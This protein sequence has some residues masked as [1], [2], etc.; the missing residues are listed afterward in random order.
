MAANTSLSPT[1]QTDTGTGGRK[2]TVYRSDGTTAQATMLNGKTTLDSGESLREGDTVTAG[3]GKTYRYNEDLGYG[4]ELSAYNARL[5]AQKNANQQYQDES[6]SKQMWDQMQNWANQYQQQTQ[7]LYDQIAAKQEAE[8][9]YATQQAVNNLQRQWEDSKGTFEQE[10][11][12]TAYSS[13]QAADNLALSRARAGDRGGIGNKQY[14]EQQNYY[15]QAILDIDLQQANLKNQIDRQVADYIAQ[16]DYENA[17]ATYELGIAQMEQLIN[18]QNQMLNYQIGVAA[19]IDNLS[20]QANERAYQR[21]L[22]NLQLGMFSPQDAVTLGVDPEQAQ[23]VAD[24]YKIMAQLDIEAAKAALEG[25]YLKNAGYTAGGG[26][27]SGGGSGGG[28]SKIGYDNCGTYGQQMFNSGIDSWDRAIDWLTSNTKLTG[29]AL[30]S[31]A[32]AYA[33]NYANGAYAKTANDTPFVNTVSTFVGDDLVTVP[34]GAVSPEGSEEK[35]LIGDKNGTADDAWWLNRNEL[36]RAIN[37]GAV[38]YDYYPSVGKVMYYING[39]EGMEWL[40]RTLR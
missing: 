31:A 34:A 25:Q 16:G 14:S 13:A 40:L 18:Q 20:L 32:D 33:N 38:L 12:K 29:E 10:R 11:A 35:I 5:N 15:D 21:A 8:T 30:T 4:E 24:N 7:Q 2:V 39:Q 27:G 17:R 23:E 1:A 37:A 28:G 26:S 3:N 22:N 19:T 6:Y 36:Q 9:D